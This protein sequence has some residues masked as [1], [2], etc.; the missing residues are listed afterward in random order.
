MDVIKYAAE[1]YTNNIKMLL[2][3][4]L[5]FL[6]AFLIPVFSPM[7]TYAAVGGT[8]L[9]TGSMYMDLTSFD[10]ALIALTFLI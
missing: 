6:L 3:F 9:R 7:P 10:I 1:A 5:P 8:F 2:F 4:S